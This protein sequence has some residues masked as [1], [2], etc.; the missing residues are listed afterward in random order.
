MKIK[1]VKQI[2]AKD[3]IYIISELT[4]CCDKLKNNPI[5]YPAYENVEQVFCKECKAPDNEKNHSNNCRLSEETDEDEKQ[6]AMV[7]EQ[8]REYRDPWEYDSIIDYIF[9]PIGYCP[10][11]GEKIEIEIIGEKN[12]TEEYL[13]LTNLKNELMKKIKRTDSKKRCHELEEEIRAVNKQTDNM[14]SQI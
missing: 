7:M 6:F 2:L 1:A 10:H 12:L 8:K 11:C 5:I 14:M 13:K 3:I 4:Y 9:Y